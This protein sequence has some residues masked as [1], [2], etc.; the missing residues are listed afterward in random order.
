MA[1]ALSKIGAQNT[2][3]LGYTHEAS[4]EALERKL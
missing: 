3:S 2:L 1:I 4:F